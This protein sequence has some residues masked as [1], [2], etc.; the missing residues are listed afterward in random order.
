MRCTQ[1]LN[2]TPNHCGSRACSRWRRY[3]Q[4]LCKL[5]HRYREQAR[6]HR[7]FAVYAESAYCTE[8]LWER[9]C[10]RWRWHI[11]HLHRLPHRDYDEPTLGTRHPTR[12]KPTRPGGTWRWRQECRSRWRSA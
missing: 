8:P 4:P 6:S 10:S 2:A 12:P 1:N 9:A 3:I 7:G 11:Q 5:T